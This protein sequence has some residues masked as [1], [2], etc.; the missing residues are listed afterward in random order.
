[1]IQKL[2]A[3]PTENVCFLNLTFVRDVVS[4]VCD[5]IHLA[6]NQYLILYI[7]L[8]IDSMSIHYY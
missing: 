2:I 7:L 3:A 1:M 5:I 8:S 4:R 6:C